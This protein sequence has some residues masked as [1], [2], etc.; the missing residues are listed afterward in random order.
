MRI[1][2]NIQETCFSSKFASLAAQ[3]LFDTTNCI[4]IGFRKDEIYNIVTCLD[5]VF[6][7][8]IHVSCRSRVIMLLWQNIRIQDNI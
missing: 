7:L 3:L 4:A 6:Q 2:G 5:K 8:V 1:L